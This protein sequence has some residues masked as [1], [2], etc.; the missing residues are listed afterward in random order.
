[1]SGDWHMRY[2]YGAIGRRRNDWVF[3]HAVYDDSLKSLCGHD[4]TEWH[5][6]EIE[7]TID[8]DKC[9]KKLSDIRA[10]VRGGA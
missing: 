7:A 1:M 4:A 2:P 5:L 9:L 6:A 3:T 8:C 10:A